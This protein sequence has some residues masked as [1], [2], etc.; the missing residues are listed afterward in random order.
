MLEKIGWLVRK[1]PGRAR[2]HPRPEEMQLSSEQKLLGMYQD[3]MGRR[4]RPEAFIARVFQSQDTIWV[5]R[6]SS[7]IRT[8]RP[9]S[10][11]TGREEEGSP[12]RT[13]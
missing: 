6:C 1:S 4:K 11:E 8:R 5:D 13:G 2:A 3:L 12:I 7:I 10:R 9:W